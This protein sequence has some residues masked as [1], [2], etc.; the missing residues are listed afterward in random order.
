VIDDVL[1][2]SVLRRSSARRPY[3]GVRRGRGKL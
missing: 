3:A 2:Q 1:G